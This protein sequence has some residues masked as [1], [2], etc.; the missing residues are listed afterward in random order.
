MALIFLLLIGVVFGL[1]FKV[2]ILIPATFLTV[3]FTSLVEIFHGHGLLWSAL[4]TVAAV[5]AIQ[6]GYLIGMVARAGTHHGVTAV[7]KSAGQPRPSLY[8]RF[9]DLIRP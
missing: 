9:N 8:E 5:I 7:R 2:R 4:A 6:M 1:G 3:V